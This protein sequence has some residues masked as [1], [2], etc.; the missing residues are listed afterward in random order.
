MKESMK[1]ALLLSRN[2]VLHDGAQWG[3]M[4]E[5]HAGM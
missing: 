5:L 1:A 2:S 4:S 3:L